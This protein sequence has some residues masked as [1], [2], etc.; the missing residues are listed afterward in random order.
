MEI[1]KRIGGPNHLAQLFTCHH[2]A[3]VLQEQRQ[4]SKWLLLKPGLPPV[5]TQLAGA[6]IQFERPEANDLSWSVQDLH[7]TLLRCVEV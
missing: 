3:R 6:K 7:G 4:D 2:F 5:L 1:H